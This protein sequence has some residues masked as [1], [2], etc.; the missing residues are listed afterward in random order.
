MKSSIVLFSKK[1]WGGV[2]GEEERQVR[3]HVNVIIDKEV[4]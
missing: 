3:F 2:E 4:G 1:R